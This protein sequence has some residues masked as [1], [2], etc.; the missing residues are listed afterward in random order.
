MAIRF[1]CDVNVLK[2]SKWLR[3]L[4]FDTL[5]IK[6]LSKIKIENLCVKDRRIFLTRDKKLNKMLCKTEIL[7][8]NSL[9]E[10]LLQILAKYSYKEEM[11]ACRCMKCN[12][13]L[14]KLE[15][16]EFDVFFK[17]STELKNKVPVDILNANDKDLHF[18][19]R[20]GNLYWHGTHYKNMLDKIKSLKEDS[21]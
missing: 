21:L 8:S 20:C 3:F 7:L 5:T 4:G 13:L 11:I 18:C 14:K 16:S 15:P 19:V 17:N 9:D 1:F 2:L 12:R 6:E 10:Q